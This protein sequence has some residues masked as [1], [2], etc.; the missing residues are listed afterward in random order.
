MMAAEPHP[1]G[2]RG[3]R[4]V[5]SG[6]A[7]K[8][9]RFAAAAFAVA[10]LAAAILLAVLANVYLVPADHALGD[11]ARCPGGCAGPY[12]R[13]VF[14]TGV[15]AYVGGATALAITAFCAAQLLGR[16]RGRAARLTAAAFVL[17]A[18]G[19]YV[20]VMQAAAAQFLEDHAFAAGTAVST[21]F[22][23]DSAVASSLE[24]LIGVTVAG[25]LAELCATA[26]VVVA[27]VRHPLPAVSSR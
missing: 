22:V 3:A 12:S 13:N 1:E 6:R 23:P 4:S 16:P 24:W 7:A 26:L 25:L 19:T 10:A 27:L 14:T 17:I 21:V 2:R 15:A 5:H 18:A 20:Y 8:I 9:P 11:A